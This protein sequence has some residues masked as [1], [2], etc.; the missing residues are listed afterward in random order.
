MTEVFVN[1][2][3]TRNMSCVGKKYGY[4]CATCLMKSWCDGIPLYP[5]NGQNK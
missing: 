5:K 4:N 3:R 1:D 2:I